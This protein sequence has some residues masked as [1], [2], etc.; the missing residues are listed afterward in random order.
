MNGYAIKQ[1]ILDSL[2]LL[3]L[4]IP[5]TINTWNYDQ[6]NAY[7]KLCVEMKQL[8]RFKNDHKR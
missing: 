7:Y 4:P 8:T 5:R 6:L 1:R 3:K 2:I